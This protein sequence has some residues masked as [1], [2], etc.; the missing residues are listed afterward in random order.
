MCVRCV[1]TRLAMS[2]TK[3]AKPWRV[4]GRNKISR[5]YDTPV[6]AQDRAQQLLDWGSYPVTV[7]HRGSGAG[8][9]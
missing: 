8:W 2:G 6:Q 7:Q 3:A 5:C 4:G 9:P 1:A